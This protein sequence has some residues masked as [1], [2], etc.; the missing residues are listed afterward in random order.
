MPESTRRRG[1]R[2]R[3]RPRPISAMEAAEGPPLTLLEL[4][5]L[6]GFS[7]D[8]IEADHHWQYLHAQWVPCG[9]SGQWMVPF[10]EARRYLT[11]IGRLTADLGRAVDFGS[12]YRT[13]RSA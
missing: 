6:A 11:Q 9:R 13:E 12:A 4:A 10:A 1:G 5:L 7:K 8:K 2:P 3:F